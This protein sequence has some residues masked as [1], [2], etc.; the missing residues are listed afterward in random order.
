MEAIS[1]EKI[2]AFAFNDVALA[3]FAVWE[4]KFPNDENG[5]RSLVIPALWV[6]Q[7]QNGWISKEVVEY[8]A[9][10]TGTKPLHVWGVATFYTMFQKEPVGEHLLQFCTN[11]SCSLHGGE[12]LLEHACKKLGIEQ[13]QTT[14]D[15]KFTVMEV[16]CLG[17][18]G[19]APVV[20][21][22][23][24]YHEGMTIDRLDQLIEQ[25]K[26]D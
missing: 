4:K 21:V 22:D 6:S 23:D 7:K 5:R 15:K 24:T 19:T 26:K 12:Q 25:L 20:Q 16:E 11:I 18:C 8:V 14:P 2:M 17:A 10:K 1:G 3:E 13:G 9:E